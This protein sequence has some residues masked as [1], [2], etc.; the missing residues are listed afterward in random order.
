[1]NIDRDPSGMINKEIK[2][3]HEMISEDLRD[4]ILLSKALREKNFQKI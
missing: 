1:M 4:H 2:D 3:L